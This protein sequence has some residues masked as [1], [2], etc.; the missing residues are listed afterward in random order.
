MVIPIL[1]PDINE[2]FSQFTVIKD[3]EEK[4]KGKKGE[5]TSGAIP[6]DRA[7]LVERDGA[8]HRNSSAEEFRVSETTGSRSLEKV[9]ISKASYRIRFGLVTIKLYS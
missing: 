8:E 6:V 9:T 4:E 3:N 1:P 2:S 7:N 5:I